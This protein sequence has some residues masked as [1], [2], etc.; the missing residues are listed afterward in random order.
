MFQVLHD[1]KIREFDPPHVLLENTKS[2]FRKMVTSLPEAQAAI[3]KRIARDKH[4]NKPYKAPPQSLA[5]E[6]LTMTYGASKNK[7]FLPSF[8]NNRIHSVLHNFH[9]NHV[10]LN[11]YWLYL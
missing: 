8:Q 3:F 11:K 2:L 1:G 6:G 7:A 9:S 10:V 5:G 4:E